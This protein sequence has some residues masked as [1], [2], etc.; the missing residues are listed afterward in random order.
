M[1]TSIKSLAIMSIASLTAVGGDMLWDGSKDEFTLESRLAKQ[2]KTLV[3]GVLH[4]TAI[5]DTKRFEYLAIS[6]PVTP[7]KFS[8]RSLSVEFMDCTLVMG[9]SLYVKCLTEDGRIVSSFKAM[10]S[11]SMTT[12]LGDRFV[13]YVMTPGK[14]GDN[15]MKLCADQV[16]APLDGIV[17]RILFQFG[18][19]ASSIP[20]EV[21][22][23]N[24]MLV[25]TPV[26]PEV[27][28]CEDYGVGINSAELRS[29]VAFTDAKGHP[30]VL[31]TPLDMGRPYLL[32]TD[33]ITGKTQQYYM[34]EGVTGAAFGSIL[35]DDGKYVI[36]MSDILVFDVNTREYTSAGKGD[37]DTLCAGL[38]PDGTVYLGSSPRSVMIAVDTASG[39]SRNLGRMDDREAYLNTIAVD[40]K[41]TVYCGIGTARANIV[42][43]DPAS[44]KRT[45][46]LPE[47]L[48]GLGSGSVVEGE[49]GFVYASFG[50]YRIKCLGGKVVEE[51]VSC[52]KRRLRKTLKYGTH[53]KEFGNGMKVLEYDLTNGK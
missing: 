48:R 34:P 28:A 12:F 15:G 40:R 35:T 44:G 9:D 33:A 18:R 45:Q 31:G 7:F 22:L 2:S 42:A 52:P 20:M 3:D 26:Y 21:R 36:G 6:L 11:P 43:Y 41:G 30:F 23:K 32:V 13:K 1:L 38:A 39:T 53:L 19:E 47:H 8:G 24:L 37:G 49:D 51:N 46:L 10:Y 29:S 17:T 4:T 14:G 5:N 25:E 16:N 50:N 27:I